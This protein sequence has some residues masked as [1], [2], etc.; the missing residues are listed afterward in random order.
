[1]N[2]YTPYVYLLGWSCLNTWYVGVRHARSYNCLYESGCHPDELW[3][4]YFTSS[5]YV[6]QFCQEN[7]DPDIKIILKKFPGNARL[8]LDWESNFINSF[9]LH[10]NSHFLNKTN[11]QGIPPLH[12]LPANVQ[13][14]RSQKISKSN[15]RRPYNKWSMSTEGKLKIKQKQLDYWDSIN[16][17]TRTIRGYQMSA[18]RT[19]AKA[20]KLPKYHTPHGNFVSGLDAAKE[21]GISHQ[22]FYER[23]KSDSFPDYYRL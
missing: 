12:S 21:A 10:K 8:A 5:K 17:D 16:N 14:E 19:K 2:T 18:G 7:G 20:K 15:K 4:T 11:N 6:K 1:M 9:S 3:E 13:T 22:A 23:C